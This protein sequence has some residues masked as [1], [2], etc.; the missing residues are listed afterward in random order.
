MTHCDVPLAPVWAVGIT[1]TRPLWQPWVAIRS[2]ADHIL[3]MCCAQWQVNF[4][5]GQSQLVAPSACHTIGICAPLLGTIFFAFSVIPSEF[6][7]CWMLQA[8]FYGPRVWLAPLFCWSTFSSG[9]FP[10][11]AGFKKYNFELLHVWMH[12]STLI[13]DWIVSKYKT[14]KLEIIL[15]KILMSLHHCLLIFKV[16][17]VKSH[18]ML[19]PDIAYSVSLTPISFNSLEAF[20]ISLSKYL[21]KFHDD[22]PCFRLFFHIFCWMVS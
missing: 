10:C 1:V 6:L 16:Y 15:H 7:Q 21:K 8:P 17:A 22:I 3:T 19:I 9:F 20:E 13:C 12:Y 4:L 11:E 5:L 18:T 14:I 2:L